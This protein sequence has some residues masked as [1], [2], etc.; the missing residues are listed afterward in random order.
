MPWATV[1]AIGTVRAAIAH[2]AG[3]T[4]LAR[5]GVGISGARVAAQHPWRRRRRRSWHGRWRRSCDHRRRVVQHPWRRSCDHRRRVVLLAQAAAAAAQL[6]PRDLSC[7]VP[8]LNLCVAPKLN[9]QLARRCR[10]P[11][12]PAHDRRAR[13]HAREATHLAASG[14]ARATRHAGG[15]V[16]RGGGQAVPHALPIGVHGRVA[17][18]LELLGLVG[19]APRLG[20]HVRD[21]VHCP[22]RGRARPVC[23]HIRAADRQ[24]GH[25]AARRAVV[26]RVEQSLLGA[27][28]QV[29]EDSRVLHAAELKQLVEGRLRG[30]E[31]QHTRVEVRVVL[32]SLGS[33]GAD[34][35]EDRV[36]RAGED[37][38][39]VEVEDAL[40][41]RE[42]PQA[43]LGRHVPPALALVGSETRALLRLAPPELGQLGHLDYRPAGDGERVAPFPRDGSGDER[44]LGDA[45]GGIA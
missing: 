6:A 42:L 45:R 3:A 26:V 10:F 39:R 21:P 33:E 35:R 36:D 38:V 4:I 43:Q 5:T 17:V 41:L 18:R 2:G 44:H 7:D 11:L 22:R 23:L 28:D 16:L 15:R 37:R 27:V 13:R 30:G 19:D 14:L 12:R 9:Q 29:A 25:L 34:R 40:V 20:A 32:G 1:R 31:E 8:K 24:L